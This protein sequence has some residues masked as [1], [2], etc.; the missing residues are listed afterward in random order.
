M[1]RNKLKKLMSGTLAV[2]GAVILIVIG[3]GTSAMADRLAQVKEA[4]ILHCGVAPGMPG[5]A[6]PDKEG[7]MVGFDIDLCRAIAAAVLGDDSKIKTTKMTLP[8]AFNAMKAGTVD[9]V[10][11]RF[12]WTFSRD[13][14]QALDYTRVMVL[15]VRA[16]WFVN[17]SAS[18]VLRN[19]MAQPSAFLSAQRP[20]Q[21]PLT[22][23]APMA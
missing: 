18:K 3:S 13:V 8:I 21:T 10:T 6:F 14:G 20:R 7:K 23:S 16:S 4:G 11:H 12:T 1:R 17:P 22:I 19:L 5:Y 15:T 9:V 2:V